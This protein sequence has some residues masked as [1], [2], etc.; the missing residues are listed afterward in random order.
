MGNQIRHLNW[1]PPLLPTAPSSARH[2]AAP[3]DRSRPSP[4]SAAPTTLRPRPPDLCPPN[5]PS[6]ED[7]QSPQ[8]TLALAHSER[9]PPPPPPPRRLRRL[10]RLG[11]LRRSRE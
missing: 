2:P 4:S 5:R 8:R 3:P 11:W 7:R 10:P 1:T 6:L 9:P